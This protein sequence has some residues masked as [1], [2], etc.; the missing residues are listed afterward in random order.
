MKVT[1]KQLQEMVR[2]AVNDWNMSNQILDL[3]EGSIEDLVDIISSHISSGEGRENEIRY[4]LK[5]SIVTIVNE[6]EK[7]IESD[8]P[9]EEKERQ[10]K[11]E[12]LP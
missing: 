12:R 11:Q 2:E 7:S 3:S 5:K 9:W 8:D 1:K 4:L 10:E 6:M